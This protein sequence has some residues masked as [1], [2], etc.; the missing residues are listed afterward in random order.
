[1]LA[2]LPVQMRQD[3]IAELQD[4]ISG[5]SFP[6][7]EDSNSAAPAV[8]WIISFLLQVSQLLP[9]TT[10]PVVCLFVFFPPSLKSQTQ[11]G[12]RPSSQPWRVIKA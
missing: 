3:V 12:G 8:L 7:L 1:M 4:D 10:Q 11:P 5:S 9:S 2:L 6:P